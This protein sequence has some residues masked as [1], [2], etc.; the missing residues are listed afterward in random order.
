M[1]ESGTHGTLL[2][3]NHGTVQGT[4][5][6]TLPTIGQL[7]SERIPIQATVQIGMRR[8]IMTGTRAFYSDAI[9]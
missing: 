2:H 7:G 4:R 8:S 3:R 5:P 9:F 1:I 6:G